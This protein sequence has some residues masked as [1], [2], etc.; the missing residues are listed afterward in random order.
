MFAFSMIRLRLSIPS[1][2]LA[3][4]LALAATAPLRAQ[5][6]DSPQADTVYNV[7]ILESPPF[8]IDAAGD[9]SGIAIELWEHLADERGFQYEYTVYPSV[10]AILQ[11]TTA[12]EIDVAVAD[13]TITSDRAELMNFTQPYYDGG[14]RIMVDEPT[15]SG[16]DGLIAGLSDAGFLRYYLWI[17]GLLVGGTLFLTLFDRRYTPKFPTRWRDGL[18]ESFYNVMSIATTGRLPN[19]AQVFG[20]VGRV[21]QGIWM[22]VGVAVVA[23]VTSSVTSVMTAQTLTRQINSLGDLP[24][25][26][27]AVL[28]GDVAEQFALERGIDVRVYDSLAEATEA[29]HSDEI[30]AMIGDAPV[31]EYYAHTHPEDS[32]DVVGPIFHPVKY[33]FALPLG[34]ELTRLLTLEVLDAHEDEEIETLRNEYFGPRD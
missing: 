18:A 12:G 14:L 22:V 20:W 3:A 7:G 29:L 23:F 21:W 19:R 13:M 15:V 10:R 4:L 6:A 17:F 11:A 2:V 5:Q 28:D 1:L 8:V 32:L 24:G 9:P 31:L 26:T 27:V 16:L 33:G 34:S 25:K 30:D